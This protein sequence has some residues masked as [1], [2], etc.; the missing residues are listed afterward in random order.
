MA[1]ENVAVV[2]RLAGRPERALP[3]LRKAR[4]IYQQTNGALMAWT[5]A[6][7]LASETDNLNCCTIRCE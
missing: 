2:H 1:Y 5:S 4:F 6:S 7:P 3:L